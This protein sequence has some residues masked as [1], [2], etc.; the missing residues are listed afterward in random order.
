[1]TKQEHPPAVETEQTLTAE[2]FIEA[3]AAAEYFAH[4]MRRRSVRAAVCL[5]AAAISASLVSAC[6]R[7][8]ELRPLPIWAAAI[9][10]LLAAVFFFGQP[11]ARARRVLAWL[12][13][14]PLAGLPAKVAV[15]ADCVALESRCEK[16]T[17]YFT[18]FSL[19]V[20]TDRLV[21]AVGGRERNL[22]V[23]KKEGLPPERA[24]ALSGLFR[25]GFDGRWYRLSGK[26]VS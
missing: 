13:T 22:L 5:T 23:V 9:L 24:K 6:G 26:G 12:G 18:D 17:E 1:M 7:H 3:A 11:K 8:P 16:M 21:A 19:C 20:E 15:R 2:D 14:C 25:Y 4:P 10:L